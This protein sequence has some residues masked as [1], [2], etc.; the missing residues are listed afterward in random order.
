MIVNLYRLARQST[1]LTIV[2]S[3]SIVSE[4]AAQ[5]SIKT[6]AQLAREIDANLGLWEKNGADDTAEIA[7]ALSGQLDE[8]KQ[9]SIMIFGERRRQSEGKLQQLQK[10]IADGKASLSATPPTANTGGTEARKTWAA[11]KA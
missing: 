4:L 6:V 7:T 3:S 5:Q 10:I 2:L 11:I 1:L 9:Q 8:F